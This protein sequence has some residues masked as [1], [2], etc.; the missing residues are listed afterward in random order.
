[1]PTHDC[2]F[3]GSKCYFFTNLYFLLFRF[4]FNSISNCNMI[5]CTHQSTPSTWLRT[6]AFEILLRLVQKT[7]PES[8]DI[9]FLEIFVKGKICRFEYFEE[10]LKFKLKKYE[11]KR[12][13]TQH[14]QYTCSKV[15]IMGEP[16]FLRVWQYRYP[17]LRAVYKVP[18]NSSYTTNLLLAIGTQ[19][20]K[21]QLHQCEITNK[22]TANNEGFLYGKKHRLAQQ[23]APTKITAKLKMIITNFKLTFNRKL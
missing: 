12:T 22:K 15:V 20:H 23:F 17:S 7:A 14:P 16:S 6:S 1:M 4:E 21:F 3:L 19:I 18:K 9:C 2:K 5:H 10:D 13:V 11:Q 8:C